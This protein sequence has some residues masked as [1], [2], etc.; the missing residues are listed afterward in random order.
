MRQ[1]VVIKF[2]GTSLGTAKK[3]KNAADIV[4]Y[5]IGLDRHPVV[6]LSAASLSSKK[7]GTTS[8]L[9]RACDIIRK[10]AQSGEAVEGQEFQ[11]IISS[12]REDHIVIIRALQLPQDSESRLL[13]QIDQEFQR[14]NMYLSASATI[15]EMSLRIRDLVI[16]SGE[17]LICIIFAQY[18]TFLLQKQQEQLKETNQ[19]SEQN[20]E[21]VF[22]N[23]DDVLSLQN[24]QSN[25]DQSFYDDLRS[26]VSQKVLKTVYSSGCDKQEIQRLV[27]PI[28]TGFVGLI[29]HGIIETVG[30]GYSDFTAAMCSAGLKSMYFN[31]TTDQV[32][33]P[34]QS[35]SLKQFGDKSGAMNVCELQI[36]KEVQGVFTADPISV[37]SARILQTL[38]PEEVAELTYYG[39]EVI[40]PFTMEQ[41]IRMSIP[42]RVLG[43]GVDDVGTLIIPNTV[44]SENSRRGSQLSNTDA[45]G[46]SR[47][48]PRVNH[49]HLMI[50]AKSCQSPLSEKTLAT[51]TTLKSN[52]TVLNI[53]SNKKTHSHGF[54]AQVFNILDNHGIVVDLI[55]TS[56]VNV[57]MALSNVS[58][59]FKS[60]PSSSPMPLRSEASAVDPS[61]PLVMNSAATNG[62]KHQ[63]FNI[64]IKLADLLA[65]L[66][67]HGTPTLVFDQC[68]LSLIGHKMKNARGT[69]GAMFTTLA[70]LGVNIEIISQG[71]SEVNISCVIDG[72]DG[73]KAL[74]GIHDT[75]V[76]GIE[77]KS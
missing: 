4:M 42:I 34:D 41:V 13:Q 59:G 55:S 2:G 69:A 58:N 28:V 44:S 12:L 75:C 20:K 54:L 32:E 25:L 30:R 24:A 29:P 70:R 45:N 10:S 62:G 47:D 11:A 5:Q 3:L 38:R 51:A 63:F 36:R 65:D 67:R 52:I 18:L 6:V 7:E 14:V 72:K 39:S 71:A 19:K 16:A 1:W 23:L 49:D 40:H 31:S 46:D 17:R 37:P 27:V 73:V 74:R 53:K 9:L 66:S 50:M 43:C 21:A 61:T 77:Q 33:A 56:E 60:S 26:K 15:G 68:I 64:S 48:P 8:R 76:L 35:R 57:S 22:C